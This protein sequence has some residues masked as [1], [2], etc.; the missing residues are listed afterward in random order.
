MR[1]D[2]DD[3]VGSD[4]LGGERERLRQVHE[5]LVQAGPPPEV[6]PQLAAGPTL[7]MTLGQRMRKR[8]RAMLLLAAAIAVAVALA[9]VLSPGRGKGLAAFE[10][11]GTSQAPNAQAVLEV[12]PPSEGNWPMRFQV[13][14]L[15]A[16]SSPSHYVVYLVRRGRIVGPCGSFT[17]SNPSSEL[18]LTLSTPYRIEPKDTWIVTRQVDGHSGPGLTVM[19]PMATA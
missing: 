4:P 11:R 19:R 17:V 13:S 10:L 8:P 5:L 7:R 12:L 9:V 1:Q 14:G 3:I 15:P 6:S 18:T 2:F 16:V